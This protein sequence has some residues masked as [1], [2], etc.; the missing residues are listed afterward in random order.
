MAHTG[1]LCSSQGRPFVLPPKR[2]TRLAGHTAARGGNLGLGVARTAQT[3]AAD[4][5]AGKPDGVE[6]WRP[7]NARPRRKAALPAVMSTGQTLAALDLQ[8]SAQCPTRCR[9][10]KAPCTL[11]QS[12]RQRLPILIYGTT[13]FAFQLFSVPRLIGSFASNC[14]SSMKPVSLAGVW[15]CSALMPLSGTP[16]L[17]G[18]MVLKKSF[19]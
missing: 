6:R 16:V 4:A 1:R 2:S 7:H 10:N 14:F 18:G 11:A 3:A 8:S 5:V 9:R 15:F 13:P 12:Y 19:H 17:V